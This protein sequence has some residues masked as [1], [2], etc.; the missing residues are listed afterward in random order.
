MC[1]H[2]GC[3]GPLLRGRRGDVAAVLVAALAFSLGISI[4]FTVS[5]VLYPSCTL[6]PVSYTPITTG[7]HNWPSQLAITTGHA[8]PSTTI[9]PVTIPTAVKSLHC[10]KTAISNYPKQINTCDG[11]RLA[12]AFELVEAPTALSRSGRGL[13]RTLQRDDSLVWVV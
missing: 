8:V 12:A 13:E 11:P 4:H 10:V 2:C 3:L 1:D 5:C 9:A 6:Y 7:H